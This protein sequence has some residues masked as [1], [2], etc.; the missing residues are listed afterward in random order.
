MI[1][2]ENVLALVPCSHCGKQCM[3]RETND[4]EWERTSGESI[5]D[6][7]RIVFCNKCHLEL[8]MKP[9]PNGDCAVYLVR[10]QP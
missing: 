1:E 4:A 2:R 5:E 8:C 3:V 9:A 6:F 7:A 10:K